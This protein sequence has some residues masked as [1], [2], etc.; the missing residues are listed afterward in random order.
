MSVIN[1]DL[2]EGRP[3]MARLGFNNQFTI[4]FLE[5]GDRFDL[6]EHE[7]TLNIRKIGST[8][9]TLQITESN[10]LVNGGEDGTLGVQ[11][12]ATNTNT[13]KPKS[14]YYEIIY[15]VGGLSYGL[16]HGTLTLTNQYNTE[17]TNEDIN[18][19]VNLAGTEITMN[20]TIAGSGGGGSNHFLGVYASLV[21]LETAYP[22]ATLGDY[23]DVDPGAGTD[24]IRYLWDAQDGW[25][26]GGS[27][28]AVLSVTS[29]NGITT[30]NTDPTNPVLKLGGDLTESVTFL[31]ALS[32]GVQIL[33]IGF[34][35]KLARFIVYAK[36]VIQLSVISDDGKTGTI[37]ALPGRT[38][39]TATDNSITASFKVGTGSG[40]LNG[41]S[42]TDGR[43]VKEGIIYDPNTKNPAD[44]TDNTLIDKEFYFD[45]LP[46]A[47]GVQTL[48]G[49]FI[50]NTDPENPVVTGVQAAIDQAETDANA[51]ADS[52]VADA[53]NNGQTSVAPS[54]NAVFDALA[55]KAPLASPTFDG[56]PAAPTA[57][58]GT[59]T[60]QL[61]TTAFVQQELVGLDTDIDY[62]KV[63]SFRSLY[64]Y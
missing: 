18:I 57:V 38:E 46:E 58:G 42:F 52:K 32:A 36:D 15:T 51:Y 3:W 14:Y 47:G 44:W 31:D 39:M 40:I 24:S 5:D 9:N 7:F 48:S 13:L 6:S 34:Q 61:A 2:S 56:T 1:T 17:N 19:E 53:I 20:L 41:T 43:T 35:R 50:D 49:E 28:G 64:G 63:A 29:S 4:T 26:E 21:A 37:G 16:L 8:L 11:L 54:Q 60:T 12:S 22:T 45:N 62:F 59:N 33:A 23:A 27:G 10:G 30:D 55:L 25:I